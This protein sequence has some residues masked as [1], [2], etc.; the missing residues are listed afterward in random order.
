MNYPQSHPWSQGENESWAVCS[1]PP[2]SGMPCSYSYY[3]PQ[4]GGSVLVSEEATASPVSRPS[5]ADQSYY[6]SSLS[7]VSP[8]VSTDNYLITSTS[9][10]ANPSHTQRSFDRETFTDWN[11]ESFFTPASFC[12]QD[13]PYPRHPNVSKNMAQPM[14]IR[15]TPS[16]S[17]STSPR[18]SPS[19]SLDSTSPATNNAVGDDSSPRTSFGENSEE[20][21]MT[22]PPYSALIYDALKDA[23]QRKLTLQDIY[24]WFQ[25]NTNKDR[26]PTSR[27]WQNSIRHNLSM[28]Q[29]FEAIKGEGKDNKPVN[30][31]RLTDKAYEEGIQSTTRY[32]KANQ[33]KG[34][35]SD[36]TTRERR[37]SGS[38]GGK[39]A[40][41]TAARMRNSPH[42]E[43]SRDQKYE[44]SMSHKPRS[45][46]QPHRQLRCPPIGA[47]QSSASISPY[48][49]TLGPTPSG[50]PI[51]S[52]SQNHAPDEV[53]SCT[54]P[55][56]G[57]YPV[58]YGTGGGLEPSALSMGQGQLGYYGPVY[59][60]HELGVSPDT[61]TDLQYV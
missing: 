32:R 37:R 38:K 11:D 21:P 28:N 59:S 61:A 3:S 17:V 47:P 49:M 55:P 60:H 46:G 52:S 48:Q 58:F 36:P 8:K 26:D 18:Q 34:H 56:P 43:Q 12:A 31:W 5:I 35:S 40:K 7:S 30:F 20:D 14:K 2:G 23:P 15:P 16:Q 42:Y 9:S 24:G 6:T 50:L 27:G 39:A 53:I 33:R 10:Q 41:N 19:G 44:N 1:Q 51:T 25:R 57:N 13:N 4:W 22:E 45:L 29:G 54:T